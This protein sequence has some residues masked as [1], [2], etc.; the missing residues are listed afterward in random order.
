[1]QYT[2]H[3]FCFEIL[4]VK[5]PLCE[6]SSNNLNKSISTKEMSI[7]NLSDLE[8]MFASFEMTVLNT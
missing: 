6:L 2:A 1:M 3:I 5:R 7:F 8:N 4:I